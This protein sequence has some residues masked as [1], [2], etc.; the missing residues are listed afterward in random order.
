MKSIQKQ[1]LYAYFML[2]VR[3]WLGYILISYGW[4]ELTDGQFVLSEKEL[5]TPLKDLNLFRLSFYLAGHQP[6]KSFVGISQILAGALL[7]YR[8][9]CI[10]GTFMSIPIWLNILVWDIT[11]L[12]S[13]GWAFTIRISYYLVLTGLILYHH[14]DRVF[15]MLSSAV[16]G[17]TPRFTYPFWAYLLLPVAGSIIEFAP[18]IPRMIGMLLG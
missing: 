8:R 14:R 6:F 10:I 3:C 16:P 18:G 11:F 12:G 15:P 4:A 7:I 2:A 5:N 1:H 17:K 13:F 9:T